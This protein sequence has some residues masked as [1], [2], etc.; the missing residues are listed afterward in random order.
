MI[1]GVPSATN[2]PDDPRK[3][4]LRVK[5]SR[6][7]AIDTARKNGALPNLVRIT[8]SFQKC[9]DCKLT[10]FIAAFQYRDSS[11]TICSQTSTWGELSTP[12]M[13]YLSE[14]LKQ[15]IMER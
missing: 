3:Q 11:G 7:R 15:H 2:W 10:G 1:K 12:E 5:R 8:R 9:D 13:L 4:Q 6:I 14:N